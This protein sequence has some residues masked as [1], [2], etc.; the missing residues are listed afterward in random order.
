MR[1]AGESRATLGATYLRGGKTRFEVWAPLAR[2]VDLHLVA[3]EDRV[4]P[5]EPAARGYHRAVVEGVGPGSR[6]LY[7]LNDK[8]RPDPASRFQPEGVHGPSE[9][10]P[11]DFAWRDR[12]WLGLELKDYVV[13]E[14]HTGTFTPEGTFDA[15]ISRLDDLKDLG[16]TAVELMPVAQ[17]PGAR[18]WGYDGVFPFAAQNSYGGPESLQR[19]IDAC[20]QSGLAVVLDVVYNHLG[21]EGNY[22]ADFGAYF[23][24][25][26]HTP[27]GPAVNFDGPESDEVRNFFIQNAL[28]WVTEFHVDA[29]RLDAVH[30]ILDH[31]PR[32]FLLELG[33]AVHREGRRLGRR[34]HLMPESADNDARLLRSA[35]LGGLGMDAQWSD[36]FHHCLHALLT[37]E[38]AGYYADYGRPDQ[39]AKAFREG[40]VYSGE[41][42]GFRRRRHGSPSR[43]IPG[44]RFIVFSQNHDQT[45]NR[46]LGER[47]S[48]LAGFEAAKLAAGA[49]LLA[50]FIPLIFM[51]E[52]YGETAPFPYFIS[53]GDPG[54]IEA[55][56][57]GRREEFRAARWDREPPDPQAE[58]TFQ[59]A[60][61]DYKLLA[62]ENHRTLFELYRQLLRLR[63][64]TPALAALEKES[65]EAIGSERNQVLF[66]RRRS[67]A[68]EAFLLFNFA[69][70]P[71][72]FDASVVA[73]GWIKV[74]D[75]AE[76]RWRG[77][78]S[79]LPARLGAEAA[80]LRLSPRAF[81]L[82]RRA[83]EGPR[84]FQGRVG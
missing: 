41:Y 75:S 8:E 59:S 64:E 18:N 7:R 72:S 25:R 32:P 45:G 6:Y 65:V 2:R 35:E 31:S 83:T 82:F 16:V 43:D 30:A 55:V 1:R 78:G 21:P 23:T 36:D 62:E 12:G 5:L 80:P 50:P 79:A 54:L 9:V 70:A 15:V 57:R 40:F 26:Y 34:V 52:E 20:H 58:A 48:E 22:L 51:G 81:V 24:A 68:D 28:Y 29:L 77:P 67:G 13:Y 10:V 42:S 14:L 27:W 39:L 53:H 44:E 84:E 71:A 49:V 63:K 17:F 69:A 73:G 38:R 56:R 61:L 46:M 60:K 11:G 37:G 66:V 74:L 4:T 3:P 47:L 19:L 33:E 76:E